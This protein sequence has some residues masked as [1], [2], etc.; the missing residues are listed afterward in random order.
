MNPN[1][2]TRPLGAAGLGKS[3]FP[4]G[5]DNRVYPSKSAA[6]QAEFLRTA[7]TARRARLHGKIRVRP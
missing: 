7:A 2:K 4:G 3:S 1:E 6:A 5:N